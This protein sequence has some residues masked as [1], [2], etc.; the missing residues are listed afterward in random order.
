MTTYR[1]PQSDSQRLTLLRRAHTTGSDE[2]G[3]AYLS[4]ETL[5]RIQAQAD[6]FEAALDAVIN[7]KTQQAV[8]VAHAEAAGDDLAFQ[9]QAARRLL[10]LGAGHGKL[11]S[12]AL[13]YY[14]L[15]AEGRLPQPS[16]RVDWL[17]LAARLLSGDVKAQAAG[18]PALPNRSD[19]E[20]AYTSH[21]AAEDAVD[22][23]KN[24]LIAVRNVLQAERQAATVQISSLVRELRFTLA[25]LPPS[26]Q[27]DIMR[28]YGLRFGADNKE[29]TDDV[30]FGTAPM[31][32]VVM[33]AAD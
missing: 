30:L 3:T 27:R 21:R 4:A 12:A 6:T 33:Q 14:D 17:P 28:T 7:A 20:A 9:V 15:P 1:S 25:T 26:R 18:L 24:A 10:R 22:Q 29:E 2:A 5:A 31:R 19:L 13:G 8:A 23:A 32:Q 11:P 16:R